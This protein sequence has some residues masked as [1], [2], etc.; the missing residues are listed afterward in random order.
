[1]AK[2]ADRLEAQVQDAEN[3]FIIRTQVLA[4]DPLARARQAVQLGLAG[5]ALDGVL[6]SSH[7]DL[8]G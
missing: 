4:G 7:P 8:Y 2:V 1:M 6:L 5:K 3:R